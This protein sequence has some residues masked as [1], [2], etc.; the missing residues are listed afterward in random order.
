MRHWPYRMH[1]AVTLLALGAC[2]PAPGRSAGPL[3]VVDDAGRTVHLAA[4]ARRIVSLAP[5]IT[6]LLFAIGAGDRV[7]GRT[8]YCLYPRAATLVPSVGDGLNPSV[9][10]IAAR[11]PDLVVLYR[12]ALTETAARQLE[13]IGIP[14]LILRHDRLEDVGRT[15]RLL[16]RFTDQRASGDSVGRLLDSVLAAPPPAVSTRVAFIVWDSPPIVI[17]AGS[18]LDQLARLAGAT[19]VFHDIGS[20]S[21][22][23]SLETIA[24]RDPD[25]IILVSDSGTALPAYATRAEWQVVRAVRERRFVVLP[26]ELYGRP[27]PRTP[28]AVQDLRQRFLAP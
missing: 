12:S 9:E 5:S 8:Q 26:G 28:E 6:E 10:A 19:N 24:A 1:F 22:T 3:S 20:A 13:R 27:S 2:R 17:G 16:G 25:R 21:A 15:A 11:R 23:V 18:Y 7:V 14:A 4:P